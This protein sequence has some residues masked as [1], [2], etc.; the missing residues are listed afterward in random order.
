M[1]IEDFKNE[2]T[3]SAPT[4]GSRPLRDIDLTRK[5]EKQ[6]PAGQDTQE[7]EEDLASSE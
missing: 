1:G 2:M 7:S 3:N 5:T 4:K 6:E